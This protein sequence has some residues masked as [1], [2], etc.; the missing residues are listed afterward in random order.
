M[1]QRLYFALGT[2][3]ALAAVVAFANADNVSR[4]PLERII[5]AILGVA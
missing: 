3:F 4:D 1:K 5:A 2:L